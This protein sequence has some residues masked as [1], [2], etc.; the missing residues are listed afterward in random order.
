[1]QSFESTKKR[2][3]IDSLPLKEVKK[4]LKEVN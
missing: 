3:Q 1:M 4:K 2:K